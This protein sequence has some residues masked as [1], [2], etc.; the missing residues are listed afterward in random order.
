MNEAKLIAD[1]MIVVS[2]KAGLLGVEGL[3]LIYVRDGDLHQFEPP[4]HVG[5]DSTTAFRQAC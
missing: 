5:P 3:G 1:P 4:V 2:V